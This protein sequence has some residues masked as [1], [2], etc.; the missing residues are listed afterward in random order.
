MDI[1]DAD[2]DP[3]YSMKYKKNMDADIVQFVPYRQFMHNPMLLAKETLT[4]VPH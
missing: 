1:L 3:L 2:D 4:E